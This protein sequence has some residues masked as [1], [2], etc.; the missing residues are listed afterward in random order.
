[1]TYI[2]LAAL[3]LSGCITDPGEER[4]PVRN[5]I[6]VTFNVTLPGPVH[7]STRAGTDTDIENID[8]LIFDESNEFIERVSVDDI[9][10]DDATKTFSV[11]LDASASPRL[12]HLVANGRTSTNL[13]R[14]NFSHITTG[15]PES[16]AIP[17]LTTSPMSTASVDQ[18]TPLVMWGRKLLPSISSGTISGIT[19]LRS[20]AKIEVGKGVPDASNGLDSF[21]ITSATLHQASAIGK[22]APANYQ[23]SAI[24]PTSP[25]EISILPPRVNYYTGNGY[26][27]TGANPVLYLYD[28]VNTTTDP[29]A[30]II[31]GTWNGTP[32]YFK[33]LLKDDNDVLYHIVRN[34]RYIVTVTRASGVG[35]PTIA[36]AVNNQASNIE[37]DITDANDE[38]HFIYADATTELGASDNVLRLYG[39]VPNNTLIDIATVFATQPLTS[40]NIVPSN[41]PALTQLEIVTASNGYQIL[42]GRWS[43][44]STG[45]GTITIQYGSLSHTIHVE[46]TG[47]IRSGAGGWQQGAGQTT[48][49]PVFT[50]ANKP[51][52]AQVTEGANN[53]NLGTVN[54]QNVKYGD[55]GSNYTSLNSADHGDTA[56]MYVDG[57]KSGGSGRA[58]IRVEYIS[59]LSY[60]KGQFIKND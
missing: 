46:M 17:A 30:L 27:A 42:R 15:M 33:V 54:G 28:R 22:V 44:T 58:V 47:S 5:G 32:G 26:I 56:Y 3:S 10:G 19:L 4:G 52:F 40:S 38:L 8:L 23:T 34:H 50:A 37:I 25:N 12:I 14:V 51:W 21:E 45:I 55:P 9:S 36:E 24:V 41:V 20:Q 7:L 53:T 48:Y 29:M 13:D 31:G 16:V 39:G 18:I 11:V 57:G 2:I 59:G 6:Q 1:M 35:F 43:N 49:C 60:M